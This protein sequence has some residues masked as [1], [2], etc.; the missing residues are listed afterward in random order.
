MAGKLP[1]GEL[2][3]VFTD[4]EGSTQLHG[5]LGPRFEELVERH[6]AIIRAATIAQGGFEVKTEGDGFFLVFSEVEAAMRACLAAQRALRAEPWLEDAPL[7]VRMGAH[8]GHAQARDGD[9]LAYPVN[10][11]ARVTDAAHGDQI[12]VSG[13]TA[14]AAGPN[15]AWRLEPHG[16]YRLKG[17]DEPEQLFELTGEGHAGS[18]LPPRAEPLQR[19]D[20]GEEVTSFVGRVAESESLASLLRTARLVTVCGIGGVGKSRLARQVILDVLPSRE[21]LVKSIELAPL[22]AGADVSPTIAAALGVR[23]EPGA[24]LLDSIE[25]ALR[26][27]PI[28]LLL[29]NCEHVAQSVSALVESLLRLC[30]ELLVVATSRVP[31]RIRGEATLRLSPMPDDDALG[32]LAERVA[33][34]RGGRTLDE[35]EGMVAMQLARRLDGLPLALELVAGRSPVLTLSDILDQLERDLGFL[36]SAGRRSPDRHQTLV[37]TLRWSLELLDPSDRAML[38]R[39]AV[40]ASSWTLE[41]ATAVSGLAEGPTLDSLTELVERGLVEAQVTAGQSRWAML[42]TVRQFM[43]SEPTGAGEHQA[44]AQALVRWAC[45]FAEGPKCDLDGPDQID[46]LRRLDTEHPNLLE[47]LRTAETSQLPLLPLAAAMSGYWV[48]RARLDGLRWLRVGLRREARSDPVL[49]V[50]ARL[51]LALLEKQLVGDEAAE[52]TLT[53]VLMDARQAGAATAR[54]ADLASAHLSDLRSF[55]TREGPLETLD[56]AYRGAIARND[57]V[58]AGWAAHFR[59]CVLG[60]WDDRRAIPA[61]DEAIGLARELRH[62]R[63]LAAALGN[64]AIEGWYVGDLEHA[65]E[66]TREGL[67]ISRQVGDRYLVQFNLGILGETLVLLG[68]ARAGRELIAERL[69]TARR[70]GLRSQLLLALEQCACLA[71]AGQAHAAARILGFTE[72]AGVLRSD[73]DVVRHRR[74]MAWLERELGNTRLA[75]ALA[76]GATWSAARAETEANDIAAASAPAG[77]LASTTLLPGV[78]LD[79]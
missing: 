5:R 3:F 66:L 43:R 32:L 37:A 29:D 10:V 65:S 20:L 69:S 76:Q 53:Q 58:A 50:R 57:R 79:E 56:A 77:T 71:P 44:A 59:G 73:E 16:R 6:R 14:E 9:Y 2:T 4:I 11:A 41:S 54:E 62:D 12:L 34:A 48:S 7:R 67:E 61:F 13:T 35:H 70:A 22:P 25:A 15:T 31:L 63:M 28:L 1:S 55:H 19:H 36:K 75:A 27:E 17:V 24:E 38:A 49:A 78:A 74:A 45:D 68:E 42:Q 26:A 60:R 18:G 51:G 52:A 8:S 47:A 72:T 40:F 33:Q 21:G 39:M 64:R 30:P 46:A 23:Q